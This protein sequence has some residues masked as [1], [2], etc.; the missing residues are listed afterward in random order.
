MSELTAQQQFSQSLRELADFYD[1]HPEVKLP[2]SVSGF[3]IFGAN[4]EELAIGARA[5]G[6]AE[7]LFT[8]TAFQLVKTFPSGLKLEFY[9]CRE[10]V[11]ERVEVGEEVVPAHVIPATEEVFI[12]ESV[13]KIYE[14]RCPD[15][16]L[17]GVSE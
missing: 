8:E 16:I 9:K 3:S 4:K 17:A 11:C 10:S 6:K 15:S 14:W 1:Q 12:P 13:K 5:F 2:G 7:K